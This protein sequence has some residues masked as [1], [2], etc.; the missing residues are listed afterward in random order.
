MC[1]LIEKKK[2]EVR[3]HFFIQC[4]ILDSRIKK[5]SKNIQKEKII[6]KDDFYGKYQ[7]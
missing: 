1:R 3:K 4:G 2:P 7:P 5:C 6:K